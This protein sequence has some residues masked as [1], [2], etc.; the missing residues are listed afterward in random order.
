VFLACVYG[1][2]GMGLVYDALRI[3]RAVFKNGNLV[4]AAADLVFWIAA[5][6]IAAWVAL[7]ANDGEIRLYM[8]VGYATGFLLFR[9]A[10]SPVLTF[11][12]KKTSAAAASLAAKVRST[13]IGKNLLK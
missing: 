7:T 12:M 9:A 5:G 10:V 8:P 2:L 13:S 3:I 4:T 11:T 6:G 1:G